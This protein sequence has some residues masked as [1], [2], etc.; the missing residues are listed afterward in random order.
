MSHIPDTSYWHYALQ[1]SIYRFIL[2][3]RYSIRVSGMKLGVFHPDYSTPWIVS[4][5]YLHNE[6]R[7][8]LRH[9]CQPALAL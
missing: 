3:E 4:L 1:L 8:I 7:A 9:K 5:P 2:E 6:V